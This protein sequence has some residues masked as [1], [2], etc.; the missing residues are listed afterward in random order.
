[1]QILFPTTNN[2]TK[3]ALYSIWRKIFFKKVYNFIIWHDIIRPKYIFEYLLLQIYLYQYHLSKNFEVEF[4]IFIL[5]FKFVFCQ[6]KLVKR[7]I[8]RPVT[9][10]LGRT[11]RVHEDMYVWIFF[12][13]HFAY[14]FLDPGYNL[15]QKK[16]VKKIT[17]HI[18]M[19]PIC[20][21]LLFNH[22][23]LFVSPLFK[24]EYF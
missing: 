23:T 14:C 24:L 18:F 8:K 6:I 12:E 3:M 21:S 11:N 22:R 7:K 20:P 9:K 4:Q 5:Y 1:M 16:L 13:K 17:R 10:K 15:D 2:F 19:C